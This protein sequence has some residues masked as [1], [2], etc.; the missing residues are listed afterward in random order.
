VGLWGERGREESKFQI[1]GVFFPSV[2]PFFKWKQDYR[3]VSNRGHIPSSLE[4]LGS[5]C[6]HVE[7]IVGRPSP[8]QTQILAKKPK[9]LRSVL[10]SR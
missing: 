3:T 4:W 8:H 1:E 9:A 10:G 5:C 6:L 2:F 7:L